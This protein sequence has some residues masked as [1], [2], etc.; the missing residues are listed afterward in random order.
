MTTAAAVAVAALAAVMAGGKPH[1]LATRLGLW[2]RPQPVRSD[3]LGSGA[4]AI[5][6]APVL[7]SG[8]GWAVAGPGGLVVGA[9][10]PLVIRRWW[11]RRAAALAR[12]RRERAVEE[13]CVVLAG[14][15]DSGV[16]A[17]HALASVAQQWPGLFADA[18]GRAVVGGDPASAIRTSA[19]QPGA[20]SLVAVAAAWEVSERT[21]AGLS[22]VLV[23]VA[24]SLRA[25][26]AVRREAHTHLASVRTTSRLM[27]V[28]PVATLVLFSAG[29]G[30]AI[31]F[32]TRSVSGLACLAVAAVFVAAG[33]F[34]VDRT[35]RSVRSVWQT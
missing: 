20:E 13:A 5:V 9:L 7:G 34:W 23:A 4:T 10:A 19:R 21:G 3:W 12:Q 6:A 14:E 30:A 32:L 18:A 8:L 11:Q 24:D 1:L 29:D 31:A 16:P 27:A 22:A 33:L 2:Q 25:E 17:R 35:A 28:L 15:L 26:A